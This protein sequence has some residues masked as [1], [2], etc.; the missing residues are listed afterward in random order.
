MPSTRFPR[1]ERDD[2]L[3]KRERLDDSAD[4]IISYLK[5]S[6]EKQKETDKNLSFSPEKILRKFRNAGGLDYDS[7]KKLVK[8]KI[9]VEFKKDRS[10]I[11]YYSN[12]FDSIVE[13]VEN[14]SV[15]T[16]HVSKTTYDPGSATPGSA[17]SRSVTPGSAAG[18]SVTPRSATPGSVT[19]GSVVRIMRYGNQKPPVSPLALDDLRGPPNR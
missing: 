12:L 16:K 17:P 13:K 9:E 7:L 6:P 15:L 8:K 3:I 19:P 1:K 11:D 14:T 4:D 18:G 10:E 5:S 2:S